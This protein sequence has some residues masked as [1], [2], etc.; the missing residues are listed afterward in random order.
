MSLACFQER[1]RLTTKQTQL[2]AVC[3]RDR[4][5]SPTLRRCS[6]PPEKATW[7]G[8]TWAEWQKQ[9]QDKDSLVLDP[10][11]IDPARPERGFKSGSPVKRIGFEMPDVSTTGPRP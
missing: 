6:A 7:N 8:L 4:R 5:L 10:L 9:G 11:L 2:Y 3:S 1:F